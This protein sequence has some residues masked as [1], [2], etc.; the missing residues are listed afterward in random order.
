MTHGLP[1]WLCFQLCDLF[2]SSCLLTRQL[3]SSDRTVS[4]VDFFFQLSGF[5]LLFVSV[6]LVGLSSVHQCC[7]K[8]S[9]GLQ[10]WKWKLEDVEG[11]QI[12]VNSW[13]GPVYWL[14]LSPLFPSPGWD[15]VSSSSGQVGLRVT[16]RARHALLLQQ[17]C[18]G[19]PPPCRS[20]G[21]PSAPSS[22][23][24]QPEPGGGGS[25]RAGAAVSGA[26]QHAAWAARPP[27]CALA[28]W[29]PQVRR[30][31]SLLCGWKWRVFA[32]VENGIWAFWTGLRLRF[33]VD[34]FNS[35]SVSDQLFRGV[36]CFC[37]VVWK[38]V[39]SFTTVVLFNSVSVPS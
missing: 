32:P 10:C 6:T 15:L 27:E 38:C 25:G 20:L 17:G 16:H 14:C 1:C 28:G 4:Q 3:C 12:V 5:S 31:P 35:A 21:F 39:A 29:S 8:L 33:E 22:G 26:G 23:Q 11:M 9:C 19:S 7:Y 36:L 37:L 30:G 34:L 13:L 18:H 2:Q 24:P